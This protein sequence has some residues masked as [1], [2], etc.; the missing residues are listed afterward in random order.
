MTK[1]RGCAIIE[2]MNKEEQIK[3]RHDNLEYE[4]T[5]ALKETRQELGLQIREIAEICKGV[6]CPDEIDF[7]IS[8]L[9]FLNKKSVW[10][11]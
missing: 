4:L 8:E 3:F 10:K 9:T 1:N 6:F 7:L 2:L 5:M 11:I